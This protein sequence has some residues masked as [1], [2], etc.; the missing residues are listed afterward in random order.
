MRFAV[1]ADI[2]GN[3]LALEAVLADI[4]QRGIHDI[5]NLGDCFSGPLTSA[6]TFECLSKRSMFT[7][8]GN[9]DRYLIDRPFEQMSS[10]EKPVFEQLPPEAFAWIRA[11][12][13]TAV[14]KDLAFA[15]HATPDDDNL[16][17]LET[18]TPDGRMALSGTTRIEALAE[19]ISYPLILCGHSHV[20]RLVELKDGRVIV[21]PGSVGIQAYEDD[22]PDQ[23]HVMESGH[24][25]ACYAEIEIENGVIRTA[26]HQISYDFEVMAQVAE[27]AGELQWALALRRGR[28]VI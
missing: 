15:C 13:Q 26:F 10:W 1:I 4:D 6:K 23:P 28:A 3:H 22:D 24:S 11:L 27:K 21:N 16:Y 5:I 7:V 8:R 2:H 12:P 20:A 9:H 19:G 14:F 18:V 17:W 25:K